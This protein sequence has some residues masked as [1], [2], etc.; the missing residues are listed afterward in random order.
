MEVV[1]TYS[2]Y[3]YI[4]HTMY[5]VGCMQC[6]QYA[7]FT[8]IP[9]SHNPHTIAM[10]CISLL[11]MIEIEVVIWIERRGIYI[12]FF[13]FFLVRTKQ[14]SPLI[15]TLT[16]VNGFGGRHMGMNTAYRLHTHTAYVC[17]YI[18]SIT[19]VNKIP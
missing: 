18:L 17:K 1:K 4:Q 13:L 2:W 10:I 6:N 11:M 9:I 3:K 14:Y 16:M 5:I 15:P 19:M 7:V 8:P 12:S